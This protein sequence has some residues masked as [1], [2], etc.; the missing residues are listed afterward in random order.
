MEELLPVGSIVSLKD[1]KLVMII[2]YSP[3]TP[4][5][6]KQYDYIVAD[7][8][9]VTKV[10]EDLRYNKDYFYISKKDIETVLF[11]GYSDK[12]FDLYNMVNKKMTEKLNRL[13]KRKSNVE[14]DDIKKIYEDVIIEIKKSE[15]DKNEK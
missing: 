9:G 11:I 1:K 12:E 15:S 10:Q 8:V 5:S 7:S 3:N 13:K 4:V 6:E 14:D 2:G